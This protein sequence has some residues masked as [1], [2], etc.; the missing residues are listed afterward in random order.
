MQAPSIRR[1]GQRGTRKLVALYGERLVC[2]R[3][4]YDAASGTRCKT[5]EL[6]VDQTA[7]TPP[8]PHPHAPKPK[9][10][11]DSIAGLESTTPQHVG[12]KVFFREHE[13][14]DPRQSRRRSLVPSGK[15]MAF[16]LSNGGILGLEHRDRQALNG[17]TYGNCLHI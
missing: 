5:V 2:V 13:L 9:I 8:P 15:T 4:R 16:A 10:E 1:H 12:V 14:R 11:I 17:A 6:I 7:W 3:Y